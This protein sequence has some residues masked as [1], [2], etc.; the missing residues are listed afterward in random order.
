[1]R[2]GFFTSRSRP[3]KLSLS[4]LD[5]AAN[6]ATDCTTAAIAISCGLGEEAVVQGWS[7][8]A[9]PMV[10]P[11]HSP[12]VVTD[13]HRMHLALPRKGKHQAEIGVCTHLMSVKSSSQSKGCQ[14]CVRC[15]KLSSMT[16]KF[17]GRS[18][19]RVHLEDM[20]E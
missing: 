18:T 14:A 4:F 1:M 3:I 20:H 2:E 17:E 15:V 19:Q 16:E 9:L 10:R 5:G 12:I 6:V 11:V 13:Q 8:V 7:M